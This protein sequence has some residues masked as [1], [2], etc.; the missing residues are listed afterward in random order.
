[1]PCRQEKRRLVQQAAKQKH[2]HNRT[3][4]KH[5]LKRLSLSPRLKSKSLIDRLFTSKK[6]KSHTVYPIRMVSLDT[7]IA[8]GAA[9]CGGKDDC[10]VMVLF[11]VSKRHFKHA[12]DRNRIKRQMRE[13]YRHCCAK[14]K[15]E[16]PGMQPLVPQGKRRLI[17]FIWLA[18]KHFE[19]KKVD[20]AISKAL[21]KLR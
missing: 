16:A 18:G 6:S 7:D 11:S 5:T 8:Q 1:M 19:S 9:G 12:V 3:K 13:A 14:N 10:P 21:E 4:Q 20:N 2:H 17:A 15:E